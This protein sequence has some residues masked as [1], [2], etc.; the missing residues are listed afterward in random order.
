MMD[1]GQLFT[2]EAICLEAA[3]LISAVPEL[4]YL[5]KSTVSVRLKVGQTQGSYA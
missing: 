5:D 4:T 2:S 1:H 3:G